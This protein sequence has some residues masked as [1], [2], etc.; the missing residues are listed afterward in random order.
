MT[1]KEKVKDHIWDILF[2]LLLVILS[3]VMVLLIA[4]LRGDEP[5][6]N[7]I[8]GGVFIGSIADDGWNE[9]H[10]KGLKQA[11]DEFGKELRIV[12]YVS[13][14]EKSCRA[15]VEE[16]AK[17]GA[18]VIFL[19]SDGFG[20][21]VKSVIEDYPGIFF[22]TISPEAELKNVKTYYGRMYQMRYL[23]GIIAG[24]MTKTNILG[25]VAAMDNTQ[26]DRGVNAYLLG[27][28]SVNPDVVVKVRMTNAWYD[29]E[30]EKEAAQYLIDEG[31]DILTHHTSTDYTVRVA[32]K[33]GVMSIAYNSINGMD[34]DM[35]LAS[36]LFRWNVLYRAILRDY[37]R[38]G[39]PTGRMYWWGI[40]EE[41]VTLEDISPLVDEGTLLK[42]EEERERF[43]EGYDVFLGKVVRA[44]GQVMCRKEERMGDD[45]LLFGMNWF[46]KGVEVEEK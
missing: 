10:Y 4:M 36:L 26:V 43:D 8:V 45:A 29:T 12:E 11:C 16:L 38:G 5:I 1:L 31:A 13:E 41:V 27:A 32:E 44:D 34:S 7:N 20:N 46:V 42:I 39:A 25:Y 37:I 40:L 30:K 9:S 17:E 6:K 18:S 15:A 22:Y 2:F 23:S 35:I 28:R 3:G 24:R 14:T 19:T 21:N 33:N